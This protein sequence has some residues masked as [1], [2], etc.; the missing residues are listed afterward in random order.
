MCK[1][2]SDIPRY[3]SKQRKCLAAILGSIFSVE[4]SRICLFET[5]GSFESNIMSTYHARY[6]T[7]TC[8][9]SSRNAWIRRGYRKARQR[10]C[11]AE[12]P[13]NHRGGCNLC[14]DH[15]IRDA[16]GV[17]KRLRRQGCVGVSKL[18]LM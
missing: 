13:F 17:I 14:E 12:A 9:F 1:M 16:D 11:G 6:I 3:Y 10:M 4:A 2:V 7:G 15:I 8:V 18:S 5:A